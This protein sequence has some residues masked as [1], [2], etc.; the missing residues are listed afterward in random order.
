MYDRHATALGFAL[1]LS[2]CG[3]QSISAPADASLDSDAASM[4]AATDATLDRCPPNAPNDGS[5]C[6]AS[7]DVGLTCQYAAVLCTCTNLGQ[8]SA[9]WS[10]GWIDAGVAPGIDAGPRDCTYDGGAEID[11]SSRFQGSCTGGCPPG[12]VCAVEI[13]GVAGG[14]GEYCAPITYRCK[15]DVTCACLAACVCGA[16]FGRPEHCSDAQQNGTVLECD[17]GIR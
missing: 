10:C 12:T 11:A 15:N 7:N 4:E 8:N 9:V 2:G 5:D 16:S 1:A 13:G 6:Y 3:G 17:N 14:G